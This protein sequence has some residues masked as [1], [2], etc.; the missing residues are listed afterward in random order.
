MRGKRLS[1][2][3][4]TGIAA[5]VAALLVPLTGS[6]S[7]EVTFEWAVV[8]NPGNAEDPFNSASV[9]GIGSVAGVYRIARHAVTNAQYADLLNAVA[10]TDTH[11]LYNVQMASDGRGGITQSGLSGSFAYAVKANMGNKPVNFV[12]FFDAMRFVNWLHNGQPSGAQD[13][14]STEGGV[15]VIGDGVSETRA[16]GAR[17]FIPTENEWYKAAYHQPST[18]GG[19]SDDYWLYPTASN[20]IPAMATANA[21]GDISNAGPNV[22]NYNF[23]ADWNGQNGNVTTVGSAGSLS[24]SYY[25]TSDQGGNVFEWNDAV[26]SGLFRVHRG[27]SFNNIG[28]A[29]LRSSSQANVDPVASASSV[30]FRVA[31]PVPEGVPTVS[32]WGFAVMALLVLGAATMAFKR[33]RV[34]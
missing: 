29:D 21:T 26:V 11:A 19:D 12:S 28:G 27:G 18:D 6:A 4:A 9:P 10:A 33:A 32:E 5:G 1:I 16:A 3:V 31:G 15:Y 20:D 22:A 34:A 30:G 7:A 14:N 25:G 2:D 23:G 13:A 24:E 8:G 17:Y